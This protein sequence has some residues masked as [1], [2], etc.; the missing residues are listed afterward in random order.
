MACSRPAQLRKLG[1]S[2]DGCRSGRWRAADAQP[3]GSNH[4]VHIFEGYHMNK[5]ELVN[6]LQEEYQ[7]WE[8]LLEQVGLTHMDQPGV[9]SQWSFKDLVAHLTPDNRRLVANLQAI[10][11]H[12]PEPPP[13]WPAHLQTDDE[14]NAWI[15]ETN[16]E[17]SV[18]Q[19]LDESHQVFQ[20]LLT[21][22]KELP[23]DV[24]IDTVHQ[25]ERVYYLVRLDDQRI[26][27]GYFF[28]H[29]HDD[30]EQ[31]V[32]AWLARIEKR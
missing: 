25:G 9:N 31:D 32:R 17:R 29:F 10:Q 18:H 2:F 11:R 8:R 14:I 20:H 16:R 5:S 6:W 30:H 7:Q 24:K 21:L 23:E 26:Q 19:V 4:K 15:Y 13:P 3:L 1:V 28:D 22:V 27:P 12:E